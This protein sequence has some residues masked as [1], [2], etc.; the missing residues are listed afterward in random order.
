VSSIRKT[1]VLRSCPACSRRVNQE[2]A[3]NCPICSG[4]GVVRL[5]RPALL[6]YPSAVVARAVEYAIELRA[7]QS[8]AAKP[9]D[10]AI[11]VQDIRDMVATLQRSGLLGVLEPG[12]PRA[13]VEPMSAT[14]DMQLHRQ[15]VDL[16][17]EMSGLPYVPGTAALLSAPAVRWDEHTIKVDGQRTPFGAAGFLAGFTQ[18][19]DPIQPL[20]AKQDDRVRL[21]R[22]GEVLGRAAAAK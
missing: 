3:A 13:N 7:Q 17:T 19:L 21:D 9:F 11:A 18:I 15:A 16:A 12:A 1:Q 20:D 8:L 10:L 14:S 6:R 2:V 4:F 22:Q 5:G